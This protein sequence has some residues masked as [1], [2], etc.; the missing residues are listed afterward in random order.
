MEVPFL[1]STKSCINHSNSH[2]PT[3][4]YMDLYRKPS[5]LVHKCKWLTTE[6]HTQYKVLFQECRRI[7]WRGVPSSCSTPRCFVC[8]NLHFGDILC[9]PTGDQCCHDCTIQHL[10]ALHSSLPNYVH[11]YMISLYGHTFSSARESSS[12]KSSLAFTISP[13]TGTFNQ[14]NL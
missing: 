1:C 4:L 7:F 9:S 3:P 8:S 6:K 12:L 2:C 13:S 11:M 10:L 5:R 14:T